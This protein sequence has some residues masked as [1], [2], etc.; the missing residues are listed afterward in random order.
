MQPQRRRRCAALAAQSG[1]PHAVRRTGRAGSAGRVRG[2]AHR[3]RRGASCWRCGRCWRRPGSPAARRTPAAGTCCWPAGLPIAAVVARHLAVLLVAAAVIGAAAAAGAC[4]RRCR[5]GRCRAARGGSGAGRDVLRRGRCPGRSGVPDAGPAASGA[6]AAVLGVGLLLRMV[7]DGVD[8]LGVAALAVPVR[9]A[10]PDPALRRRQW[11][12]RCSSSPV[13]SV[14]SHRG[15]VRRRPPGRP[16]RVCCRP[17]R[18][19]APDAPARI[20]GGVRGPPDAAAAGRVG[21]RGRRLLPADR[22]ARGVDDRVPGRQSALRRPGRAG[23]V[24]RPGID[25]PGTWRPC[26]RCSRS[27]WGRSP[28]CGS[29]PS[30]RTRPAGG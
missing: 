20:G 16:R 25:A 29:R 11:P 15:R 14:S 21:C 27:R 6:T 2:V 12:C 1:D 28:R 26:S 4:R 3:H 24:L 7:G 22:A 9:P 30:P 8:A 19:R 13:P 5:T 18:P 23:R 10:G 17:V